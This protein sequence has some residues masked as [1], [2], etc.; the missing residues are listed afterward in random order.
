MQTSNQFDGPVLDSFAQ[1]YVQVAQIRQAYGARLQQAGTDQER[2]QIEV[3]ANADMARAVD[4]TDGIDVD[5]FNTIIQAVQTDSD[6]ADQI[7]QR[8]KAAQQ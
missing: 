1:A 2:R 3:E 7:N 4:D 6:L 5:Q 8:L